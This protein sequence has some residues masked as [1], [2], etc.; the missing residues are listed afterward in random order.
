[1]IDA[2]GGYLPDRLSTLL[3]RTGNGYPAAVRADGDPRLP[4]RLGGVGGDDLLRQRPL[5]GARR[6][7]GGAR[8]L[9]RNGLADRGLASAG[10][11][12]ASRRR[13]FQGE[14]PVAIR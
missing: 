12:G 6:G 7:V 1:Q 3:G 14:R 9:P 11:P 13:W 5:R 4:R 10:R 2:A 8:A